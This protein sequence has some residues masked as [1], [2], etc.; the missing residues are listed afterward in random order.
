MVPVSQLQ[1]AR[2]YPFSS[3]A[4]TAVRQLVPSLDAIDQPILDA[5]IQLVEVCAST[6]PKTR[7]AYVERH[8]SQ[9]DLSYPEFLSRDVS[10]FPVT[11]I[12]LSFLH[13][14]TL[15]ERFAGLMGDL[16]FE[17]LVN[18][19]DRVSIWLDVARDLNVKADILVENNVQKLVISL[20][21]YLAFPLQDGQ[22]HLV[23][24]SV[25]HGNIVLE[26]NL[27]CRWL[28]E[29][30]HHSILQSLPVD[31]R[32]FPAF[33]RESAM[34][35]QSRINVIRVSE[36]QSLSSGIILSAFP[37]CM[38]KLYGEITSGV[39]LPHMAR[40]DLATF[41]INVP[42]P[43]EDIVNVFSKASNYDER[44]TRYHL[45][46]LSGRSS[47]KKYS[48]PACIK[49]R[50]HGLCISRTCNVTH[51]LQFY[52]RESE[53]PSETSNDSPTVDEKK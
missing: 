19:K 40:F 24:Q 48:M 35:A 17:Y 11:K 13:N 45:D 43:H 49:V 12:I 39:N 10:L 52:R 23:N 6:S 27:A 5:A 4:K 22:L 20:P 28:A 46:N 32:G 30:V 18:E 26:E 53:K 14:P 38:V 16:T 2:K 33:L 44:I 41:L 25:R 9:R 31:T 21:Q 34:Q 8:F 1:F 47:G 15:N 37:P 3:I 7:R 42:M 51:P 50:E 36:T 29:G